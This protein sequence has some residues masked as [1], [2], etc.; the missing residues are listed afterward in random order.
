MTDTDNMPELVTYDDPH[1]IGCTAGG[2]TRVRARRGRL[3][4]SAR[5]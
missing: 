2:V 1:V 3:E 5:D 4:A